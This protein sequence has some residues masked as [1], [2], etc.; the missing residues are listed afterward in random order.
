MLIH[1]ETHLRDFQFWSGGADNANCLSCEQLDT[2]EEILSEIYPD[3]IDE[4]ALNDL[5]WF[6]EDAIAEWLGYLD[7]EELCNDNLP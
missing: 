1:S 5:I 2:I 6:D 4:T 3:G 7:F